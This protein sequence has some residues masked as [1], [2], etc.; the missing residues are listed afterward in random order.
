MCFRSIGRE[1]KR[2]GMVFCA[3]LGQTE[4]YALRHFGGGWAHLSKYFNMFLRGH[5]SGTGG[6]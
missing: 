5:V 6:F 1:R 3:I 2:K 4:V